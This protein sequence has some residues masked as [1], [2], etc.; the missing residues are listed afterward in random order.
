MRCGKPPAGLSSIV[1]RPPVTHGP[2]PGARTARARQ[3]DTGQHLGRSSGIAPSSSYSQRSA[4]QARSTWSRNRSPAAPGSRAGERS[5]QPDRARVERR[6]SRRGRPASRAT[7]APPSTS[8]RRR[9]S[10]RRTARPRAARISRRSSSSRCSS[11]RLPARTASRPGPASSPSARP[12]VNGSP[13]WASTTLGY[14]D[15]EHR[16]LAQ[17]A[18]ADTVNVS[19]RGSPLTALPPCSRTPVGRRSHPPSLDLVADQRRHRLRHHRPGREDQALGERLQRR[20]GVRA[21]RLEVRQ[22]RRHPQQLPCTA[23]RRRRRAATASARCRRRSARILAR[24]PVDQAGRR[25]HERSTSASRL[26]PP[27]ERLGDLVAVHEVD[28]GA[29]PTASNRSGRTRSS[30]RA[31][32]APAT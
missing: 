28:A 1:D 22:R 3:S 8:A 12:S 29:V 10:G 7:A 26:G 30:S 16:H 2:G 11:R 31:S 9:A 21:R 5:H 14:S 32:R 23:A 17:P 19:G 18:V 13:T 24:R 27:V 6:R 20:V 25:C 15:S 4:S